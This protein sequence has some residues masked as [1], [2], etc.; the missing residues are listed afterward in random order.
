MQIDVGWLICIVVPNFI[1][2]SQAI[3][4]FNNFINCSIYRVEFLKFD[5]LSTVMLWKTNRC[6]HATCHQ[7]RPNGSADIAIFT[8][9]MLAAIY[10]LK[11]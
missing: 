8:I 3:A 6:H 1:K 2:I 4:V 9:F 5:F 7:N 10:R 11:F